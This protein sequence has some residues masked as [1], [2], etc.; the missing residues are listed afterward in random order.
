MLKFRRYFITL[1]I[2]T[3][4][5]FDDLNSGTYGHEHCVEYMFYYWIDISILYAITFLT[6]I[7]LIINQEIAG[8]H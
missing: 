1:Q 4:N 6:Y 8:A 5:D 2:L 7:T 3:R